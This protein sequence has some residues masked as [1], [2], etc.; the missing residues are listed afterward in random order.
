MGFYYEYLFLSLFF[1]NSKKHKEQADLF[2]GKATA[3]N[4]T[5]SPEYL[6]LDEFIRKC[7]NIPALM[8]RTLEIVRVANVSY[9]ICKPRRLSRDAADCYLP[10]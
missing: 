8:A 6:S 3:A 2:N 1:F 7:C 10:G 9:L 4:G 5:E